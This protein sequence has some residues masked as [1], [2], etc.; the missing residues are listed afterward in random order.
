VFFSRSVL[1][2]CCHMQLGLLCFPKLAGLLCFLKL[3]EILWFARAAIFF[4]GSFS[5][6]AALSASWAQS[7]Y[8]CSVSSAGLEGVSMLVVGSPTRFVC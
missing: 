5:V 2:G 1:L 8:C 4:S 3:A 6:E 7:C